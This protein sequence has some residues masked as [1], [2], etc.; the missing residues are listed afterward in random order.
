MNWPGGF[1]PSGSGQLFTLEGPDGAMS[2]VSIRELQNRESPELRALRTRTAVDNLR[3]VLVNAASQNGIIVSPLAEEKLEGD[4]ALLSVGAT[5]KA[6]AKTGFFLA[7]LVA[8][9]S[10]RL[11]LITLEGPGEVVERQ[12]AFRPVFNTVRWDAR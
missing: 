1:K 4:G 6:E 7:Y 10:G 9:P 8:H 5:T 12:Q 11:A 2:L 3:A